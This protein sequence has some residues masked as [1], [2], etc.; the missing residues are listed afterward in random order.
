MSDLFE[1][2]YSFETDLDSGTRLQIEA[3]PP[4]VDSTGTQLPAFWTMSRAV[5]GQIQLVRS[6]EAG[7][8]DAAIAD[9]NDAI[10]TWIRDIER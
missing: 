10:C 6:G 4:S 7:S 2:A 5:R 1:P 8:L 3:F 9:A